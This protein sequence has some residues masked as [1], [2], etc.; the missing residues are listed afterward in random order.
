MTMM[1]SKAPISKEQKAKVDREQ[2]QQVLRLLTELQS[3]ASKA[4]R[5]GSEIKIDRVST[6]FRQNYETISAVVKREVQRKDRIAAQRT[7]AKLDLDTSQGGGS[8]ASWIESHS[9]I[10]NLLKELTTYLGTKE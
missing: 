5:E 9:K 4:I 10:P 1:K 2:K 7:L 3:D 8:G 6:K